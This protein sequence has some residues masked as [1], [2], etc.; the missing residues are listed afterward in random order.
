MCPGPSTSGLVRSQTTFTLL[1]I[2]LSTHEVLQKIQLFTACF[3]RYA[4]DTH[5]HIVISVRWS[6]KECGR[7]S[8]LQRTKDACEPLVRAHKSY[9]TIHFHL[10]TPCGSLR[11]L[12]SLG[13]LES[14]RSFVGRSDPIKSLRSH[15]VAQI[16]SLQH[17]RLPMPFRDN[18]EPRSAKISTVSALALASHVTGDHL[19]RS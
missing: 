1:T 18:L 8:L 11:S 4:K 9:A 6:R 3:A 16:N 19:V 5:G 14:L 10:L 2:N 13:S 17:T 12:G 15:Q 7:R